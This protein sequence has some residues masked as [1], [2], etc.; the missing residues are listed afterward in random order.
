MPPSIT[1]DKS[2]DQVLEGISGKYLKLIVV[3]IIVWW[4]VHNIGYLNVSRL[5]M[6]IT[7]IFLRFLRMNLYS[8]NVEY[9]RMKGNIL[10]ETSLQ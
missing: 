1:A 3:E 9:E 8:D 7:H 5:F 10:P 4:S 2:F 6:H